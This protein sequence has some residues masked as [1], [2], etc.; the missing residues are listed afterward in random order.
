MNSVR[1]AA[2]TEFSTYRIAPRAGPADGS[3]RVAT[4]CQIDG[5]YKPLK[6]GLSF[7][8]IRGLPLDRIRSRFAAIRRGLACDVF[9]QKSLS[10]SW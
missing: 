10:D 4:A 2:L 9:K 6:I 3:T 8:S 1:P 5:N 7:F